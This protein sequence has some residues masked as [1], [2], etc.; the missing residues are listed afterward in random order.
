[1][2]VDFLRANKDTFA[3][4]TSNMPGIPREVAEH[5]LRILPGS[6]PIQQRLRRFD[7][8]RRRAIGVE[9]AKLLAAGFI[10]EVYHSDWLSNPVLVRK[11][12]G[13]WRM[14]V[15]FTS[16]N[17]ACPKDPFPLPRIDQIIDSTSGCEILSFL[18]AYSGYHQLAMKESDQLATSFITPFGS[19]CYVSMPF[20]LKNAGATYQRC[21]QSCFSDQINSP[22]DPDRSDPPQATVAVYVDDIVVKTPRAGDLVATLTAT[23]ANLRRFNIKLNPEKCTFGVPKG[24]LVGYMVSEHGIESNRDK[25]TTITSMGPIRGVK[26]VQRLT[27]CLAVLSRFI[28]RLGERG[29]P[30]Y[31]LLKKSDT[32]VWMEEAQVALDCLK[33]HLSSPPVVVAPEPCEP[34]LLY[35][36]ATNHMVNDALV[37]EREEQGH[38]LKVQRPMY[39]VSEVLTDTKSWYPQT[40]KLLYT[41][42]MAAKKLQHYFTEHEVSVVTSFPLGEVVRNRDAVGRISKWV[43]E[44]MGYDVKFVPRTVIKSQALADFIAEWTEVH[45]PTPEISHEYWTPYFDGSVMGP[46]VGPGSSWSP[47]KGV[48]SKYEALISGLRIA[49]DIEATRLYVYGDSKLVIDQVMKNSNCESPL[50]DAYYQEVRKLEGR[51]RGLELHHIPRKQNPDADTLAKMAAERKPAPSGV[52]INDLNASSAR[53]YWPTAL[54]NTED[55]VRACKGCQFY[56]KQTHL[57]AQA[58]QTIPITWTFTVWG[59]DMV[60]PLKKAPGGF[61]HLLVAIDKFTKWI[62]AKP[63]TT[64]D[65]KEAVKFFLDIV[66]RFGVPNSIITDNG[67]NFTGHYFQEFAEGYGIRIDWASVGH[68]RT[69]GQVERANGLILQGL[70][71]R[72]FGMLKKFTGR[73]V[74]ELLAVLWS[75]R[76][77]PNRST[78]LTPFFLTYGSE[79]VLPSDLDFGVPRVKTFDPATA[80]EAQ[81]DAMEVLEEARLTTLLRSARYQQTLRRYHERRIRERALQVGDLVLRRVMA[82]KDKHKL[83]PHG[84]DPA[85]SQR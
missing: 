40:Q 3:W 66:Y 80:A 83:S 10:K 12:T 72:I 74:E 56:A 53:I 73:W 25:I 58:L 84:K 37:V 24:K 7:D 23:F 28:A 35:L 48:S 44:L 34:L 15:D 63:I 76:T 69:N 47:Q 61:T 8:E 64:I 33:A 78:G 81:R 67:T 5:E 62:E 13:Q 26:G 52:F 59:L 55:I 54:R 75:L 70:K 1:M 85:A 2:L 57:P 65:S 82:T 22:I 20:G 39:F 42:I 43:V 79:A 17:K 27:G 30:L 36:A 32:F 49:I 46:G 9:I 6:K 18:D 71:P 11:K 21:M 45:A 51:F 60:G 77:T 41:I 68:P 16:L 14:C 29:L 50:M 19:Y 4:K 31:K 38:A